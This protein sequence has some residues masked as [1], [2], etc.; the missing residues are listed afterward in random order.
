MD[1][2]GVIIR[3]LDGSASID[4]KRLLFEW[5]K[6]SDKN[7]SEYNEIR[8]IWLSCE[9]SFVDDAEVNKAFAR[10]RSRIIN[11]D[12]YKKRYGKVFRQWLYMTAVLIVIFSMGHWFFQPHTIIETKVLVTQNQLITAPQSKGKFIL[13]DSTIVWLNA[14]SKLIYPEVFEPDKRIVQLEGEGYFDVAEDSKK[15]FI[16]QTD[17][18]EV[19]VLGTAFD[20]SCYPFKETTDVVLIDGK[21]KINT[22]RSNKRTI[23]EPNQLFAYNKDSGLSTLKKT[24]ANLH[25]DWIKDRLIFDNN[26]LSDIIISLEGWYNIDIDCPPKYAHTTRLSFTVRNESIEEIM[27]GISLI[28][29]IR[30]KIEEH[31]LKIIPNKRNV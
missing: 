29:P 31:T 7:W 10:F 25:I 9:A 5:L 27:R 11:K 17:D 18:V 4:D 12:T 28:I 8:D 21:V 20:I 30:Y 24:K 1:I 26:R 13:P 14:D 6:E 19:E 15:P 16:V 23:M 3:Y 22:N 2:N